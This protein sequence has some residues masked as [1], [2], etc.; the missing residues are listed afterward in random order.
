MHHPS[1]WYAANDFGSMQM[2][3]VGCLSGM[4]MSYFLVCLQTVPALPAC[5]GWEE[6]TVTRHPMW[7]SVGHVELCVGCSII[8]VAFLFAR[9]KAL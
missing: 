3:L 8:C 4:N 6:V 9:W 7:K 1:G 5:A 2:M